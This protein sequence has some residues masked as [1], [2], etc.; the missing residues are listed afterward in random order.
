MV[1]ILAIL[2]AGEERRPRRRREDVGE[3]KGEE[4]GITQEQGEV[5]PHA[6]ACAMTESCEWRGQ[7]WIRLGATGATVCR[8]A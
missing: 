5:Q 3:D 2:T 8:V 1:L 4:E 7:I 6:I